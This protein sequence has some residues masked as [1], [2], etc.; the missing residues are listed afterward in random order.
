MRIT[1][2]GT[3]GS[4]ASPVPETVRYGGNTACVE[5]RGADGT[6]LV[7]DAGTGIRRLGAS[8]GSDVRRVDILLTHL[9]MDHIQGLGFFKPLEQPGQEVHIWGPPSTTL[10][11]RDRLA[12]YLS[13]PLFPVRLRDLPCRLTLH[14]VPLGRFAI[15]GLQI[16]AGLVIHPGPTVGYRI[17][18]GSLSMAY[19]PDHEPALGA[20][21]FPGQAVWTS[22]FELATGV[23]LL[24]HDAQYTAAQYADHVGWGHSAL[25]HT[26]AFAA[27]AGV[28]HLVTFHHDP[29]HTDDMLDRMLEEGRSSGQYAFQLSAGA[30]G[31]TFQLGEPP[32]G[33]FSTTEGGV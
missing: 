26:L 27:M 18:E 12:R 32:A 17:A 4:L 7:L 31:D 6:L 8:V 22:G 1:L 2:W 13:P 21:R 14:H 16:T 23:D 5:V 33:G 15:G 3:R 10:D 24:I 20:R 9:H 25:P 29:S 19:L 11:L 30:E 28:K